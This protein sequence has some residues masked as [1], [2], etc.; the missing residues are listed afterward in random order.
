[1]TTLSSLLS[2]PLPSDTAYGAS[3]NGVTSTAP[4]KNAVYDEMETKADK[5]VN[6]DITSMTGLDNDGI[7]ATKIAGGVESLVNNSIVDTLHRHSELV[8]S[9]GSPDPALSVDA[10]GQ[11]CIN[12]G[13]LKMADNVIERAELKDYSETK[14]DISS[15][16]GVLTM[17]L[18]NG[19]VFATTLTENV[20][21]FTIS[22]SSPTGKAC[23]FTLILT[24]AAAAKSVTWA[25]SI[26]WEDGTAPTINTNS[27]VY[28][29]TFL[30]VDAGTK[31]Y[32]FIAGSKMAV[33]A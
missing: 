26:R 29:F 12:N 33:P 21:T 20:T 16:S 27:A 18:A 9:D 32:G 6:S 19:N 5:G 30:T 15:S 11:I 25:T 8:A 4:S 2:T 13:S 31:W 1:M 23:S 7:P 24:Q 10:T 22:N 28:I 3:W 14:T 17:N